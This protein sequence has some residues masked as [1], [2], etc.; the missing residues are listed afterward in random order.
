MVG[1]SKSS[2]RY[3]LDDDELPE[4]FHYHRGERNV[5]ECSGSVVVEEEVNEL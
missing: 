1:G 3:R 2:G 4:D 5:K